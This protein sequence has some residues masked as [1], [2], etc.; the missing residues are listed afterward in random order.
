LRAASS[1]KTIFSNNCG[2]SYINQNGNSNMSGKKGKMSGAM[3]GVSKHDSEF[4]MKAA[5][6]D[7]AEINMAQMALQK[8]SNDDVK[9][10]AQMMID[11]H[12]RM[13]NESKALAA[14]KG[15]TLP[16]TVSPKQMAMAN[17]LQA[18]SGADFDKMYMRDNV[19]AHED[20]VKTF[21]SEINGGSDADIKAAAQKNLPT[22]QSHLQTARDISARM[23]GKTMKSKNMN[24]NMSG[25]ANSNRS[26]MSGDMVGN[27][28]RR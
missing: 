9:R 12:T 13:S 10:F 17:S 21:Q 2:E 22:I 1:L 18:A 11:D 6:S 28:N 8:S 16:A 27:S 23:S 15:I 7:M 3:A 26:S 14:Q 24:G 5:M 20:A 19:K 25:A 4:M